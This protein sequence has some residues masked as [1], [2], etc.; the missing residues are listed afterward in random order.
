LHRLHI[1]YGEG[2]MSDYATALKVGTT[3]CALSLV[4][5]G[6]LG[7]DVEI[8][9]P[10]EALRSVSRDPTWKW[11]VKRKSGGTISAVDLQ[12]IYLDA[13]KKRLSG[14]DEQTDWVLKEWEFT[15]DA[16]ER[17]PMSLADRLDWVAK[18]KIYQEFIDAEGVGW[19]DEVMQSLDLE[20]HNVNPNQSLFHALEQSGDM[21]RLV[22]D[23]E[24]AR[25]TVTAPANTRA[26]AR[27]EII[28]K[29]IASK[30]R[31]YVIDWDLVYLAKNRHLDLKNPFD[32]YQ[33]EAESFGKT[34]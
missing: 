34:I 19:Q 26:A 15:L 24:I 16:L 27:A 12:R 1:L 29:L 21:L 7:A 28:A 31:D 32:T 2:N 18:R 33:K 20:Y 17:D 4:E 9:D 22:S 5:E 6:L 11:Q 10:L 25:A 13:S 8:R 30:S 14:V 3:S 23:A